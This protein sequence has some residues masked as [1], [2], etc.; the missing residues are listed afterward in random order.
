MADHHRARTAAG[1]GAAT[2]RA[3]RA[4]EATNP[5]WLLVDESGAPRRELDVH[6]SE[7]RDSGIT[8]TIGERAAEAIAKF[9]GAR[10]CVTEEGGVLVGPLGSSGAIEI[11]DAAGPGP[12]S[13]R[14]ERTYGM[15]HAHDLAF[16]A[17]RRKW[18]ANPELR[19]RGLWHL[20]PGD[21]ST[22][23]SGSDLQ[24]S[25]AM[26]QI[27]GGSYG[28]WL[29]SYVGVILV[30]RASG[31][32]FTASAWVTEEGGRIRGV[33]WFTCRPAELVVEGQ[34]CWSAS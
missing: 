13:K 26:L 20:H 17:D 25:A 12:N 4:A 14:T 30:P 18:L 19:E 21:S 27:L 16:V 23:P 6:F 24:H 8:V 9:A 10:N 15:D 2:A 3:S 7:K 5:P 28:G 31:N 29:S 22:R 1:G 33:S 34:S 11:S 32:G